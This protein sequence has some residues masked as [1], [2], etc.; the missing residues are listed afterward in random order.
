MSTKTTRPEFETTDYCV[1]RRYNDFVWLR[2]HLI[3]EYPTHFIP[4][5]IK[6]YMK[7]K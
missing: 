5:S 6:V 4:V 7:Q 2:E 3:E 1:R